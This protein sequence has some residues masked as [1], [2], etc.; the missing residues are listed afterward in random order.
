MCRDVGV[1]SAKASNLLFKVFEPQ[2][3]A[4]V[5]VVDAA[6]PDLSDAWASVE[7]FRV[8]QR[9][10]LKVVALPR[11]LSFILLLTALHGV[12]QGKPILVLATKNDLPGAKS[13]EEIARCL[14]LPLHAFWRAGVDSTTPTYTTA[15]PVIADALGPHLIPPVIE[16]VHSYCHFPLDYLR[17]MT[18]C[19]RST[20]DVRR[21]IDGFEWLV[22]AVKKRAGVKPGSSYS[23]SLM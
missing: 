22:Q 1:C 7:L 8:L 13:G 5:F 4:L 20:F 11:P 15:A 21:A 18:C 23:C 9:D 10:A 12:S 16:L 19:V 14:E 2:V 17:V 6:Q 3:H